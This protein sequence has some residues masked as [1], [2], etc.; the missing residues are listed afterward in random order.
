MKYLDKK[1][2]KKL[3]NNSKDKQLPDRKTLEKPQNPLKRRWVEE[4]TQQS[5]TN[6]RRRLFID[7]AELQ[8][9]GGLALCS[10]H[11]V[12]FK[13]GKYWIILF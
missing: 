12:N 11:T 1:R 7:I 6:K 10:N 3:R 2:E 5:P 13:I 9:Y 4:F 8:H